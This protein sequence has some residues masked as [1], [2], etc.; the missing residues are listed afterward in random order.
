MFFVYHYIFDLI[1]DFLVFAKQYNKL[2]INRDT[3]V[4]VTCVVVGKLFFF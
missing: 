2:Y 4:V 1:N 3:S